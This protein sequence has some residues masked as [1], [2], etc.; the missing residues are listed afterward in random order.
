VPVFV[1]K[2]INFIYTNGSFIHVRSDN[3]S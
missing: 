1:D 3:C 2:C